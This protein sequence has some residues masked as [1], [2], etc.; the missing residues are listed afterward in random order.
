VVVGARTD[1]AGR[2]CVLVG[3][4]WRSRI[5]VSVSWWLT[6]IIIQY[7]FFFEDSF[8]ILLFKLFKVRN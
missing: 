7:L 5:H 2:G 1:V 3:A 4:S 6:P 8:G